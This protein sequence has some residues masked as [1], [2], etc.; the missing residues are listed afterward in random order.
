MRSILVPVLNRLVGNEPGV[1]AASAV[2]AAAL[3]SCDVRRV[4]VGD[5]DRA[6]VERRVALGREMKDELVAVVDEPFA[7]DGL[8]MTNRDIAIEIHRGT[9]GF[10]LDRNRFD[11]VNRVLQ[12]Q[13]LSRGPRDIH[14]GPWVGRLGTDVEEQRS[15]VREHSLDGLDPRTGPP[16]VLVL[17]QRV[18]IAAVLNAKIVRRGGDHHRD[19]LR[20]ECGEDVEAVAEIEAERSAASVENCMWFWKRRRLAPAR[21]RAFSVSRPIAPGWRCVEVEQL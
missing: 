12:L 10:T 13:V 7:V 14:R 11:P 3:P 5:A 20:C 16:Q 1:P 15:V 2:L 8:V 4:L 6:P 9:R 21:H 17:G 19:R 18:L